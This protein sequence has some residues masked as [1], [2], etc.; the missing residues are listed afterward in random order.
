MLLTRFDGDFVVCFL[1][2]DC[3]SGFIGFSGVLLECFEGLAED[4]RL[5]ASEVLIRSADRDSSR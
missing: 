2:G 1:E 3:A 4:A 5:S